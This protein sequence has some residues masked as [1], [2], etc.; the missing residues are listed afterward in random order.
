MGNL[1]VGKLGKINKNNRICRFR[2]FKE[3]R[4]IINKV[5]IIFRSDGIEKYAVNLIM[6]FRQ[7]L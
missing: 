1:L 2:D 5:E 3:R 6:E 4:I 7:K